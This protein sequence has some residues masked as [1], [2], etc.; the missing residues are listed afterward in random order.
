M[1]KKSILIETG[2][3]DNY[4]SRG[5]DSEFYRT[6]IWKFGYEVLFMNDITSGYHEYGNDRITLTNNKI[7]IKRSIEA[8]WHI[9]RKYNIAFL[10]YPKS[11]IFRLL[12]ILKAYFFLL[13][14]NKK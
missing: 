5:I 10:I 4:L 8:Q 6:C 12:I 14:N 13:F 3:F 11:L 1:T 9:I 7:S 2:G